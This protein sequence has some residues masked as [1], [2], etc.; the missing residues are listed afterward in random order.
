[1][2]FVYIL[3]TVDGTYYTGVTNNVGRRFHEHLSGGTRSAKYLRAH[4]PAFV[5]YLR[6]CE[7][8]SDALRLERRIKSNRRLKQMCIGERVDIEE[9]LNRMAQDE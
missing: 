9:F 1:M 5:V 3:E 6:E 7:S 4:P 2:V 8:L